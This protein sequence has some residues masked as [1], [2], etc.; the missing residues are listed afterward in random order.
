MTASSIMS[1][2][3]RAVP[4]TIDPLP[5]YD[6]I[7]QPMSIPIIGD[8]PPP[9]IP[10]IISVNSSDTD[11]MSRFYIAHLFALSGLNFLI[12]L[13]VGYL[14]VFHCYLRCKKLS[15]YEYIVLQK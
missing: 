7:S 15:T 9:Q 6:P 5:E 3:S 10:Q 2:M 13:G 11:H 4:R 14:I 12:I 1:P 8:L